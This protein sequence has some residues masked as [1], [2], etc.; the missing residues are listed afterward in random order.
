MRVG[1]DW[2]IQ[3]N[4]FVHTDIYRT[5][6]TDVKQVEAMAD[7]VKEFGWQYVSTV[8]SDTIYG[9]LGRCLIQC[10]PLII[11]ITDNKI[12]RL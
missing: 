12:L 9:K 1:P 2:F 3:L 6:P 5:I 8:A 10:S 7:L 4:G 11:I